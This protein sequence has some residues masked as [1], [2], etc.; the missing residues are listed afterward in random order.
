MN[1]YDLRP[2]ESV[3][4]KNSNV[5]HRG[6]V[7]S[8]VGTIAGTYVDELI[9]TNWNLIYVNKSMWGSV[10]DI[11]KFPVSKIKTLNGAAQ[12]I[13]NKQNGRLQLQIFFADGQE[14]FEFQ[15][16]PKREITKWIH[17]I[18]MVI[19]QLPFQT[20]E[21]WENDGRDSDGALEEGVAGYGMVT[22]K[23]IGCRAPLSGVKGQRV[24]CK[25]C[26]TEQNL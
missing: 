23:C 22:G 8:I 14:T 10:K 20:E 13:L 2:N 21:F 9:L 26:D 19:S 15:Y 18:N 12:A 17:E 3:I 7:G 5:L 24:R 16:H 11:Q 1:D 4:L 6:G 25:Y